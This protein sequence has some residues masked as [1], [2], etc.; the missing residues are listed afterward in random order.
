MLDSSCHLSPVISAVILHALSPL[1][2]LCVNRINIVIPRFSETME[3]AH[4]RDLVSWCGPAELSARALA[5]CPNQ[6]E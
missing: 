2:N 3:P 1:P 6:N 5:A 4:S